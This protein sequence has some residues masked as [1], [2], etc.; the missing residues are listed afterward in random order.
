MILDFAPGGRVRHLHTEKFDTSFLGPT[1]AI[2][3]ASEVEPNPTTLDWEVHPVGSPTVLFTHPS[4]QACL[5]WED[6]H[7]LD[8]LQD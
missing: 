7:I 3:R 6:Q 5:D 4:R 1:A 8:T 2:T